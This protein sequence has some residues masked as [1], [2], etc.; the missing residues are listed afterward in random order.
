ME[1]AAVM[2]HCS[3]HGGQQ[4]GLQKNAW[5]SRDSSG[6]Q[7]RGIQETEVVEIE[8]ALMQ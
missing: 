8:A 1:A 2:G 5:E 6:R 4:V 3:A 7:C